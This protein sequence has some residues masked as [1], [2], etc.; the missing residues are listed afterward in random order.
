MSLSFG[1]VLT[2][3]R[4]REGQLSL[5]EWIIAKRESRNNDFSNIFEDTAAEPS[6]ATA[7]SEAGAHGT[8]RTSQIL[9]K[10]I[11]E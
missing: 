1:K 10:L 3:S 7:E 6:Q 5:K 8:Y 11:T 9:N 2:M 4:K